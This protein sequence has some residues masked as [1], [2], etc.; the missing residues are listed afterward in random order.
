MVLARILETN[1]GKKL[2]SQT[3]PTAFSIDNLNRVSLKDATH[4]M[5]RVTE[6]SKWLAMRLASL[7][8]FADMSD[9]ADRLD[10]LVRSLPHDESLTLL[11]AHPELSPPAP[12]AMTA[13]S[14][15]E[16]GRL[17]LTNLDTKTRK[18]LALLN[19]AYRDRFGF[20]FIIALHAFD[21]IESVIAEFE[22]RL[23][24]AP[25]VELARAL[26][27]V[28]SVARARLA[29]LARPGPAPTPE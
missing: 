28:V 10:V 19:Q 21:D 22:G 2:M 9:I 15:A 12:D 26:T 16:Q 4:M 24:N 14:Q 25:S 3:N 20:P 8:P 7:R 13:A 17:A 1:Q 6:R 23:Q 29:G 18:R 5:E 11:R 27:E